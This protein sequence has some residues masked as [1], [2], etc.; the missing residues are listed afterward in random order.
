MAYGRARWLYHVRVCSILQYCHSHHRQPN[1]R[2]LQGGH[3]GP[4]FDS[5]TVISRWSTAAHLLINVF[6]TMLLGASNYTM[7][8][9]SSP[10]RDDIDNAHTKRKWLD[11][12]VL[13]I[14]N[15]RNI[16][17]TR[18]MVWVVLAF[19]SVPLHLFY[20]A[21]IF[22]LTTH[23]EYN[24]FFM[25]ADS[26]DFTRLDDITKSVNQ[27]M[28]QSF[29]S[30]AW[31]PVYNAKYISEFGDLYLGMHAFTFDNVKNSTIEKRKIFVR[32]GQE[33]IDDIT[34][35]TWSRDGD[36]IKYI[37]WTES[38]HAN[39]PY[40]AHVKKAIAKNAESKSSLQLSRDFMLVVISF[41]LLKLGILFWILLKDRSAY[42]VTLGDAVASFLVNQDRTTEHAC[43]LNKDDFLFVKGHGSRPFRDPKDIAKLKARL[44]GTW[45]PGR[46]DRFTVLTYDKQFFM[47]ALFIAT[48]STNTLVPIYYSYYDWKW[49]TSSS[50]TA[51]AGAGALT[52]AWIVNTPQLALSICYLGLNNVCTSLAGAEEWNNIG[53]LRKALRVTDPQGEQRSTYFLQLPYRWSVPLMLIS[54]ILP[55]LLSQS[56]FLLRLNVLEENVKNMDSI[57][58]CGFSPMSLMVFCAV[59]AVLVCAVGTVCMKRMNQSMPVEASCSFVISAAC[60][61]PDNDVDHHLQKL[62]WGV[63]HTP[64]RHHRYCC[65]TSKSGT[66][67]PIQGRRYISM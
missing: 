24:I 65:I 51:N 63:V 41:N 40:A 54:S 62:R 7:Q 66:K 6:S 30:R 25:N 2:R 1:S 10:T 20:N 61:V 31:K 46:I 38:P 9:M 15:L 27:T 55:W 50:M 18:T 53:R 16:P 57:S 67:K 39:F 26:D 28:Y 43:L 32:G 29:S 42:I 60:H 5:A 14:R 56:F 49:S 21:A 11:I 44:E 4:S 12:G 48:L 36:W 22:Q 37:H 64:T 45:T 52:N 59:A 19:S 17:R 23:N 35:I 58:A 47:V 8:V 33:T 3:R 13:S 34:D